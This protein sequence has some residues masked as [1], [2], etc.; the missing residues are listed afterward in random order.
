MGW[1]ASPIL[2]YL[3]PIVAGALF[4]LGLSPFDSWLMVP[5]SAALFTALLHSRGRRSGWLTGWLYGT[6]FFGAGASW[7]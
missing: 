6:G 4:P 7:V 1:K 2:H 3:A 5:L